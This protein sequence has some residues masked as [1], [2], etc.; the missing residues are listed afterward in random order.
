LTYTNEDELIPQGKLG[1]GHQL[2]ISWEYDFEYPPRPSSYDQIYSYDDVHGLVVLTRNTTYHFLSAYPSPSGEYC[3]LEDQFREWRLS[4]TDAS[5]SH[6]N[7]EIESW[8]LGNIKWSPSSEQ[9]GFVSL[10]TLHIFDVMGKTHWE[11]KLRIAD[12]VWIDNSSL[13]LAVGDHEGAIRLLRFSNIGELLEEHGEVEFLSG[14]WCIVLSPDGTHVAFARDERGYIA[15]IDGTQIREVGG[16]D[17]EYPVVWSPDGR[18]LSFVETP[19]FD[20]GSIYEVLAIADIDGTIQRPLY[21]N[22]AAIER[23]AS[24]VAWSPDSTQLVVSSYIELDEMGAASALFSM[25]VDGTNLRQIHE[26]HGL[27]YDVQWRR[28]PE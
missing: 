21:L 8:A 14:S 20:N 5:V 28:Q 15:N 11:K 1:E 10:N 4:V 26:A 19:T 27:I 24:S 7:V 17:G 18:H 6:I 13:L 3:L 2:I 23:I 25:N 9:F 22:E 12:Y 16:F